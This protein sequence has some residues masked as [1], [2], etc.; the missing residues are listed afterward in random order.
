M[1]LFG[2][3]FSAVRSV[4]QTT[5]QLSSQPVQ[6]CRSCWLRCYMT[7]NTSRNLPLLFKFNRICTINTGVVAQKLKKSFYSQCINAVDSFT[8]LMLRLTPIEYIHRKNCFINKHYVNL[9]Q[10]RGLYVVYRY[11]SNYRISGVYTT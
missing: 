11:M 5:T 7:E 10:P 6:R 8:A 9:I 4:L 2:G 3:E 1:P